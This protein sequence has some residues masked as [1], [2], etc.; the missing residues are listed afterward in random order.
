MNCKKSSNPDT[1]EY[2]SS[3]EEIATVE[4]GG[5]NNEAEIPCEL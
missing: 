1:I 4:Y 5:L 2:P 3:N